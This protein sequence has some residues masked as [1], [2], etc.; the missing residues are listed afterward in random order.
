MQIKVLRSV[1]QSII[2]NPV[3]LSEYRLRTKI[4]SVI[5]ST[6]IDSIERWLDVG[7]GLR[8]YESSFPDGVYVGVDV[9]DSGRSASLKVPDHYFDGVTLPFAKAN[10][11][12]VISTQVL[13]HVP[14]PQ[15]LLEEMHRVIKPNG[16]LILSLPFVWQEHEEPYDYFRFT[17]FRITELL[18]KTGFE[19][20]SLAKDTGTIEALAMLINTYVMHNFV[21]PVG[22]LGRVFAMIICLPIQLL[23]LVL[24]RVLPDKRQLYLNLVVRA[25][26]I[27]K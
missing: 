17:Q 1:V 8:P 13:E 20:E 25:K 18:H 11:E 15:G 16:M 26:R 10:F 9:E 19:V 23:A 21:P 4:E 14:N 2:F 12:G 3:W 5:S 6:K 7:C 27:E 24:Q 22:G